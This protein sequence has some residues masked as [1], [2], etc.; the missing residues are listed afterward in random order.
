M[1]QA[2]VLLPAFNCANVRAIYPSP[3]CEFLLRHPLRGTFST[4]GLAERCERWVM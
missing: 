3:K 1:Q 2:G 4:N